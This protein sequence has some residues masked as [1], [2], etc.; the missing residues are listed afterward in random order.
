MQQGCRRLGAERTHCHP[1]IIQANDVI[2]MAKAF[3]LGGIQH[4]AN[5]RHRDC[6]G[7]RGG[8]VSGVGRE[9]VERSMHAHCN[10]LAVPVPRLS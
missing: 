7:L 1:S 8:A 5:G 4:V 6:G 2:E 9:C 3:L 10:E